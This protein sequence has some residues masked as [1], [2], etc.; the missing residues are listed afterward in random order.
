MP[1]RFL[2]Y[3][4]SFVPYNPL[5]T[6][7]R[8]GENIPNFGYQITDIPPTDTK[9]QL[10]RNIIPLHPIHVPNKRMSVQVIPDGYF[11]IFEWGSD[12]SNMEGLLS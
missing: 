11:R 6:S 8:R 1:L 5:A 12:E 7:V 10:S 3:Y 4:Y 2:L 9:R